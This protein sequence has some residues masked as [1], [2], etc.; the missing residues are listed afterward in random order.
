MGRRPV[1]AEMRRDREAVAF[2]DLSRVQEP[3]LG[4]SWTCARLSSWPAYRFCPARASSTSRSAT[5]TWS[6]TRPLRRRAS[7]TS[8]QR[9]EMRCAFRSRARRS[10]DW[11]RKAVAS[12]SWSSPLRSRCPARRS[13]RD[14]TRS[15]PCSTS[16]RR[17]ASR[18]SVRRSSSPAV[19]AVDSGDASSSA[20]CLLRRHGTSAGAWSST[21][22][23]IPISSRSLSPTAPKRASIAPSWR[24]ISSWSCRPPRRSSMVG[25]APSSL[26]ATRRRLFAR[27]ARTRSYRP[28]ASP[29]GSWRWRSRRHSHDSI[30]R[31]V[32]RSR[33]TIRA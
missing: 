26:R 25:R 8:R 22:R 16:C 13:I 9:C 33:S 20:C 15:R 27:P 11:C 21:T 19:S 17:S 23:P 4:G 1:E 29:P 6:C 28:P 31:S 2:R 24:P 18:T 5:R 32:S 7:S 12:P 30:R 10:R 14:P 3:P